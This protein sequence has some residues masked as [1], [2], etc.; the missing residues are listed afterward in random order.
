M[1]LGHGSI[2]LLFLVLL[3]MNTI[4]VGNLCGSMCTRHNCPLVGL[5]DLLC[6]H[7]YEWLIRCS[8]MD[9]TIRSS[10]TVTVDMID[11][12]VLALAVT[13][14]IPSIHWLN[15][16][17]QHSFMSTNIIFVLVLA[18]PAECVDVRNVCLDDQPTGLGA[19]HVLTSGGRKTDR[20]GT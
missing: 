11:I 17:P 19:C 12:A 8:T 18:R 7:L 15:E 16:F 20:R 10:L 9:N 14:S 5:D 1:M 6:Q 13:Q 2:L 4:G 3:T